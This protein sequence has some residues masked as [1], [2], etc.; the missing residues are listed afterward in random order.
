MWRKILRIFGIAAHRAAL[1][2][3]LFPM[4]DALQ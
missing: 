4:P 3:T 2:Q 1:Q